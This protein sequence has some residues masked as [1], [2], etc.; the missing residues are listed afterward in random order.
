[1]RDGSAVYQ[2]YYIERVSGMIAGREAGNE[3]RCRFIA[4]TDT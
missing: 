1:M 2:T 3:A 4:A